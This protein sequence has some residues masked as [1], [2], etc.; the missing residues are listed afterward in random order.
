[1]KE[2]KKL[3]N[4]GMSLGYLSTYLEI[5]RPTLNK[6]LEDGK[7]KEYQLARI[8]KLSEL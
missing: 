7:F 1:M 8:K 3:I 6:R 5:S 4:Q 2:L